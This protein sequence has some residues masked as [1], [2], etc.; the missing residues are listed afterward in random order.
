MKK[1][2]DFLKRKGEVADF[3]SK[4]KWLKRGISMTHCRYVCFRLAVGLKKQ[5]PWQFLYGTNR[6][7]GVLCPLT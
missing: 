3:N 7:C 4:H 6:S 1:D 2:S 5:R